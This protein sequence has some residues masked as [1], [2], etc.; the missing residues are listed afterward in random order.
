MERV[1]EWR[2]GKA[3]AL[4]VCLL[5]ISPPPPPSLSPLPYTPLADWGEG[6]QDTIKLRGGGGNW[7]TRGNQ[8]VTG[9][10]SDSPKKPSPL[11]RGYTV[12]QKH[13]T[14][15]WAAFMYDWLI[16]SL[17]L[18]IR[19]SQHPFNPLINPLIYSLIHSVRSN[20]SILPFNPTQPKPPSRPAARPPS[21]ETHRKP[22]A[23]SP[24]LRTPHTRGDISSFTKR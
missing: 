3:N 14:C 8:V 5:Y 19:S 9:H 24:H 18:L 15:P 10:H 4:S 7:I 23:S 11:R 20:L 22:V 13:R 21:C 1:R 2:E 17:H 16:V 6:R 12:K